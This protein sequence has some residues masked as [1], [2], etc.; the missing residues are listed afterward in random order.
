M[1]LRLT[2]IIA[3]LIVVVVVVYGIV[4][5]RNPVPVLTSQIT[6][7]KNVASGAFSLNWP[8]NGESAVGA[9]GLGVLATHST[10]KADPTAS[11]AKIMNAL[12]IL[13]ARPLAVGQ[14]GPTLT[15]TQADVNIYNAYVAEDGSVAKVTAGEQ[16]TEY[17]ALEAMLLPSADNI[18]DTLANWA[19]GSMDAYS[20]AA[21]AYAIKLGMNDTH[22]GTADASGYSAETT[23]TAHD[24]V[25]LGETALKNP[26]VAQI[27]G[28]K[29]ATVPVAGTIQN[30]NWL[31]GSHDINGIKTGN[32]NEAGGV[33]L[34]SAKY[35]IADGQSVELVG[36]IM[37]EPTL[38]QALDD[39]VPLLNSAE[40]HFSVSTLVKQGQVLGSYNVPWLG[41]I[42]AVADKT[43]KVVTWSGQDRTPRVTLSQLHVPVAAGTQVGTVGFVITSE[44]VPIVVNQAIPAP[45]LHWRLTH[46]I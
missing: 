14:P 28:E 22:F 40:A 21:N 9:S 8:A 43:L 13:K 5:Y 19:Y 23:S 37:S 33:Y 11:V 20:A 17:Q 38:L 27:V 4:A 1:R 36:A 30:V 35:V 24:L 39:A 25:L 18:A 3:V 2:A 42:N 26:I 6:P 31:L 34:F 7:V 44:S 41:K 29:E 10:Q 46:A 12:M 45:S 15:L 32:T 16:I